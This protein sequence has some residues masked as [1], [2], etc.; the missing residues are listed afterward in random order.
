ML[1]SFS[2]VLGCVKVERLGQLYSVEATTN[3]TAEF[4]FLNQSFLNESL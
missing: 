3:T 2:D 4:H 1:Y